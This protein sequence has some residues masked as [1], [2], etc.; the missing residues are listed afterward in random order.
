LHF[1][2]REIYDYFL[3]FQTR[4]STVCSYKGD[5]MKKMRMSNSGATEVYLSSSRCVRNNDKP[6]DNSVFTGRL[7][8]CAGPQHH[9]WQQHQQQLLVQADDNA[10]FFAESGHSA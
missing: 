6:V 9:Q 3:C 7:P 2:C 8:V 1:K 10:Q 5:A 4:I